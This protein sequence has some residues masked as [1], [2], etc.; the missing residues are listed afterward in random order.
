VPLRNTGSHNP[1]E[2]YPHENFLNS[3][4]DAERDKRRRFIAQRFVLPRIRKKWNEND[5]AAPPS[6]AEL[7]SMGTM[8]LERVLDRALAKSVWVRAAI[9][10]MHQMRDACRNPNDN[11]IPDERAARRYQRKIEYWAAE[12]EA[13]DHAVSAVIQAREGIL[14]TVKRAAGGS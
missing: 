14:G 13:V 11:D 1:A 10:N 5:D 7:E 9:T 4:V 8:T 12:R 2:A 6:D 3:D